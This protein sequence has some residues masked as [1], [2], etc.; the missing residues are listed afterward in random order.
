MTSTLYEILMKQA[1]RAGHSEPA[2]NAVT[3]LDME[4]AYNDLSDNLDLKT[5]TEKE[6][7]FK[8]KFASVRQCVIKALTEAYLHLKYSAPKETLL[9]LEKMKAELT[10]NFY[11]KQ[12]LDE[13]ILYTAEI[14]KGRGIVAG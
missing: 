14:L 11:N 4:H 10:I 9:S 12:R 7:E 13:I 8:I 3:Y 2:A 5:K 1:F 6:N